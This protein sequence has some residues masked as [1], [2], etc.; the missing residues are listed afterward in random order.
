MNSIFKQDK[1]IFVSS[2]NFLRYSAE[3]LQYWQYCR[4]FSRINLRASFRGLTQPRL[5]IFQN[6]SANL[7]R[8]IEILIH[9]TIFKCIS[10]PGRYGAPKS[11]RNVSRAERRTA[12]HASGTAARRVDRCAL[13]FHRITYLSILRRTIGFNEVEI[14]NAMARAYD[15]RGIRLI[16]IAYVWN[17]HVT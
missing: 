9:A 10:S 3:S 14:E 4:S 15:V 13:V 11:G 2:E 5:R 12:L 6:I 17:N 16:N 8:D 1:Y 7:G